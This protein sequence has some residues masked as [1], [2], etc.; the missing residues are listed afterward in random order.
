MLV[1]DGAQRGAKK[2]LNSSPDDFKGKS[3][4]L[5]RTTVGT[6]INNNF[7]MKTGVKDK[8]HFSTFDI[9]LLTLRTFSNEYLFN[10]LL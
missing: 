3:K 1:S 2:I 9:V 8:K 6:D 5:E 4:S 7:S 10:D